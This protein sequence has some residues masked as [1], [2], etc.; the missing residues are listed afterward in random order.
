M[1]VASFLRLF[2]VPP[3]ALFR[4]SKGHAPS[5]ERG[6]KPFIEY[7][8]A[9]NAV[10][11]VRSLQDL[12]IFFIFLMVTILQIK[13]RRTH[14]AKLNPPLIKILQT[15]AKPEKRRTTSRPISL[16]GSRGR[17]PTPTFFARPQPLPTP[18]AVWVMQRTQK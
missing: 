6:G 3:T 2:L 17:G 12:R 18:V 9:V 1:L 15:T 14:F 8:R 13:E 5:Q 10:R 7:K 11:L 4:N 16:Q